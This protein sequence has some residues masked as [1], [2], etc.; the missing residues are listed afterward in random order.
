MNLQDRVKN[1]LTNPKAEWSAIA[2]EPA[3]VVSLYRDYIVI[4]AAIPAVCGFVGMAMIGAPFIVRAMVAGYVRTLVAVFISAVAVEKL[5]PAFGSSGRTAH[6]LEV[7]AYSFT[8]IWIAGVLALIPVL[9][10]LT[11]LAALWAIYLAY[12]GLPAVMKTP[13]DKVVPYML[14]SALVIFVVNFLLQFL[15]DLAGMPVAYGRYY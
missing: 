10:P 7:V 12:L 5:A 6:A 15:L 3:D 14:V 11:P 9:L 13:A 2:A 4:L 1:I 8:P